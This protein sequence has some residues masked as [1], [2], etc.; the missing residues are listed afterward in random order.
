MIFLSK[1]FGQSSL[2][3]TVRKGEEVGGQSY[4]KNEKIRQS[5][6]SDVSSL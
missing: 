1:G 3:L 6:N 4:S 5:K 2:V